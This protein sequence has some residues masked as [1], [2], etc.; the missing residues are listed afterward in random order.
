MESWRHPAFRG[1][2]LVSEDGP[3]EGT[4]VPRT[5]PQVGPGRPELGSFSWTR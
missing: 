4:L 5:F 3:A 2:P 1:W